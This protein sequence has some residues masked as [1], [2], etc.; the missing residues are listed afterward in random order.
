[1]SRK[2]PFTVLSLGTRGGK[3]D[4][5]LQKTEFGD[6]PADCEMRI[7]RGSRDFMRKSR[8]CVFITGGTGYL[9]RPLIEQLLARGHEVRALVRPGSEGKLPP[10][11]KAILGNALDGDS[12]SGQVAPADTFVQLVGVPHPNPSKAAEFRSIDLASGRSAIAA[13]TQAGVKHFVYLSVAQPAPIMKAYIKVR[14][15]CEAMI[16]ASGMKATILRPWYVLGT[17]HRWPYLLLPVYKLLELLPAT[18]DGA[19]R[20]GLVTH[21]QMVQALAAAV[22]NPCPEVRIVGVPEIRAQGGF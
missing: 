7:F 14:A 8:H 5:L 22:E 11:S 6:N 4:Y 16:R 2:N 9:G 21:E 3:L 17:G 1:M 19:K 18:R 13:A 10:G 12:Y 15:E 20:L